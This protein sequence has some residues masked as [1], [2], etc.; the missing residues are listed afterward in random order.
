MHMADALI[1]PAVGLAGWA[2]AAGFM[3]HAAL[4]LKRDAKSSQPALMGV[5]GA[6][7]FAAQM[8]NFSIPGTGASGHLGGGLLLS[9]LLGPHAAF[10]V[11]A[12]VLTVQALLFADGGL[13]ALG[14][15]IVNLGVFTCFLAYPLLFRPV[16]GTEPSGR[17]LTLAALVS[18]VAGLVLGAFAVVLETTASGISQLPFLPFLAFMVP[19]HLAIGAVEGLV[20]GSVLLYVWRARPDL[21]R[22]EPD[23]TRP[24]RALLIGFAVT[25]A[26]V[27]GMLSW[28]A[29]PHPD[30]LEWSMGQ[31]AGHEQVRASDD[32]LHGTLG[33][34][35]K[36]TSL[37]PDYSIAGVQGEA[38]EP[39]WPAPD[40][41][42][43]LSATIG[44]ALTLLLALGTGL[45]LRLA[46]G[47]AKSSGQA[48]IP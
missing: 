15:N 47:R 11:M 13:L 14:C 2:T 36:A 3:V 9:A 16:A 27:G 33:R 6:F 21:V 45:L 25:T 17:R 8:V 46:R 44:A 41:G 19:I 7:V 43:S 32:G 35:Q 26:G 31:I 39:A 34:L 28:F 29:S 18:A 48:P 12:S 23:A 37:L 22:R 5:L 10:L 30:G 40:A 1:S 4:Q 24:L 42:T 20:T 38:T